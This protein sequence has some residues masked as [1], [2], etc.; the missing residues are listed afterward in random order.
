[1]G[2]VGDTKPNGATTAAHHGRRSGRGDGRPGP[3]KTGSTTT[4]VRGTL[5]S[6]PN[7]TF[8]VQFFS[9]PSGEEGRTLVGQTFVTTDESGNATFTSSPASKV[10]VGRTVTATAI[11]PA[12]NTSKFSGP[13]TVVAS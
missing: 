9:S 8:T 12:G 4:T 1:M 13:T 2:Q 6:T 11:D 7:K 3:P 5:D 10:G